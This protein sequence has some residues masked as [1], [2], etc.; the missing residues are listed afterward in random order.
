MGDDYKIL[1]GKPKEKDHLKD[2]DIDGKIILEWISDE[3]DENM[4]TG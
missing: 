3:W 1:V 2:L 4:Q